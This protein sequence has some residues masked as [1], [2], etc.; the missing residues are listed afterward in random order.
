MWERS[1][2]CVWELAAY[3]EEI[4][5]HEDMRECRGRWHLDVK[6]GRGRGWEKDL[7]VPFRRASLSQNSSPLQTIHTSPISSHLSILASLSRPVSTNLGPR[8]GISANYIEYAQCV[9]MLGNGRL[10][11]KCQDGETRLGQIRGQMR[12]KVSLSLARKRG[13]WCERCD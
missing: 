4:P 2:S 7:A 3:T 13:Q 11:A 10:E 1:A 12:K 8:S 9:K 6:H 5:N